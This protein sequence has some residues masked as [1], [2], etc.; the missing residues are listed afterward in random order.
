MLKLNRVSVE[1]IL[2]QLNYTQVQC[3][4]ICDFVDK[5]LE[6]IQSNSFKSLSANE[7]VDELVKIHVISY[8]GINVFEYSNIMGEF[9]LKECCARLLLMYFCTGAKISY[10]DIIDMCEEKGLKLSIEDVYIK[11]I[12]AKALDHLYKENELLYKI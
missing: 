7:Y 3:N 2:K 10:N 8:A 6:Y 5:Q 1:F 12:L 4:N 9:N 11:D